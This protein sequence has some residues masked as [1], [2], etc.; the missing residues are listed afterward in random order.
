MA[1][2][3]S[4]AATFPIAL[5]SIVAQVDRL[6]LYLDG[7]SAIPEP[8]RQHPQVVPILSSEVPGLAGDG[9]FLGM[10]RELEPCLY[11]T[12]DDDIAYPPDYVVKLRAGLEAHHQP[13]VVGYHGSILH[14]PLKSYLH[15]RTVLFFGAGLD[16]SRVVDVLGAGTVMF[17]TGVLNFDVRSWSQVN[18]NDLYLAMEAAKAK[19][20]LIC[21]ARDE[22]FLR[23]IEAE[24]PDSIFAALKKDD[25][26]ETILAIQLQGLQARNGLSHGSL[27]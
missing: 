11:L 6:Y 18:K 15:D 21:L 8:V 13:V 2:M 20:P 1:T 7:H 14:R 12:V 10:S 27:F 5:A 19:L 16:R 4:R 22:G 3:P 17:D 25:S 26:Q 24:Q 23:P 9:K